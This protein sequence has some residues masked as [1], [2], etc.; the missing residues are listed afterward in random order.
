M[1]TSEP[2]ARVIETHKVRISHGPPRGAELQE[3]RT[4]LPIDAVHRLTIAVE[5]T[6]PRL[7]HAGLPIA[8]PFGPKDRRLLLRLA[9]LSLHR[10]A[11]LS[12]ET[13]G[14]RRWRAVAARLVRPLFVV[15]AE[16]PRQTGVELRYTALVPEVHVL[17]LHRTPQSLASSQPEPLPGRLDQPT[18]PTPGS[19]SDWT[20]DGNG[21]S[22]SI[23]TDLYVFSYL[24]TL[25][26]D[27]EKAE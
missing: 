5:R 3:E 16:V 7:A 17:V 4:E 2:F 25:K 19:C 24:V 10:Q 13:C 6:S 1:V 14:R 26:V 9:V 15:E 18:V 22:V 11:V 20:G 27:Y 23:E 12:S 8:R 21:G